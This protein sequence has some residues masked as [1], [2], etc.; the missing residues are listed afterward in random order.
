MNSRS[1]CVA[2][3]QVAGSLGSNTIQRVP[4]SML[5]T[6]SSAS[7]FADSERQS[8]ATAPG[9]AIVQALGHFAARPA[10]RLHRVDADRREPAR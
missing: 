5:L 8:A 3:R 1:C 7:R 9:P 2:R 10:H 6:T 4:R